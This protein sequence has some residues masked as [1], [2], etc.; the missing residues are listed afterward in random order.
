MNFKSEEVQVEEMYVM[1][2]EFSKALMGLL[3]GEV[4]KSRFRS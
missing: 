2:D 3:M 4:K 1:I